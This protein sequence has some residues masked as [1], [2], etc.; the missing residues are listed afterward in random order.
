MG[1]FSFLFGKKESQKEEE[2]QKETQQESEDASQSHEAEETEEISQQ[3]E[4]ERPDDGT[5]PAEIKHAPICKFDD[6]RKL[7]DGAIDL[8][9]Y[10]IVGIS[11]NNK[12][13][14]SRRKIINNLQKYEEIYLKPEPD[15]PKDSNAIA[16]W[17]AMGQIGYI[18]KDVCYYIANLI[19]TGF[20]PRAKFYGPVDKYGNF[21][22][23]A[24]IQM[25]KPDSCKF[26]KCKV[27][28]IRTEEQKENAEYLKPGDELELSMEE[29]NSGNE[30]ISVSHF[31]DPIGR[32]GKKEQEELHETIYNKRIFTIVVSNISED[33]LWQDEDGNVDS[34]DKKRL[35]LT[36][37][38][39]VFDE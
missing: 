4:F 16:V 25:L 26:Y 18:S 3:E 14:V 15:N 36:I 19:E 10:N 23:R 12:D 34:E 27:V 22:C 8:N 17:S 13:G 30:Y 37:G 38:I 7:P 2:Q 39:W 21:V 32:L 33:D 31:S 5:P 35:G 9:G 11:F 1:L 20:I 6:W 29:T 28:G 24:Y